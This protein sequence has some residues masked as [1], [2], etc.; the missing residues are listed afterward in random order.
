MSHLKSTRPLGLHDFVT[1]ARLPSGRD[2]RGRRGPIDVHDHIRRRVADS[3]AQKKVAAPTPVDTIALHIYMDINSDAGYPPQS[4]FEWINGKR[5]DS[6][7]HE[8]VPDHWSSFNVT[9]ELYTNPKTGV[10]EFKRSLKRKGTIV[11][12]L[13]HSAL[14]QYHGRRSLGL[15]PDLKDPKGLISSKDLRTLLKKSQASMV[16]IASCD[17]I[18]SVGT[19]GAGPIVI[20]TDSGPDKTTWS[21]DWGIALGAF[22]FLLIG[23]ELDPSGQPK[24]RKGGPGT[25]KEALDASAAAFEEHR[26]KD[27]FKL[28]HGD[29][30]MK[31]FQ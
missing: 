28:M 3:G 19:L 24:Q 8:W 30:S 18:T 25:I 12:Y 7:I 4:L 13:G 27:R 15:H 22:L 21:Q 9:V 17:S 5:D 31:V 6:T 2:N 29:S 23:L 20:A 26:T 1:A 16:I 10:E 11:V 14:D